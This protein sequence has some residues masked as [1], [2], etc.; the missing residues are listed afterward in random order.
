M[1]K[2]T[3][4]MTNLIAVRLS[5]EQLELL[6]SWRRRQVDPPSRAEAI[7]QLMEVGLAHEG[8]AEKSKG[9]KT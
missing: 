9:R 6:N 8:A 2:R 4:K 3:A 5:E 1:P 7:R